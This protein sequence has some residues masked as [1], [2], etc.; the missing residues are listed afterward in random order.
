MAS[1]TSSTAAAAIGDNAH[2]SSIDSTSQSIETFTVSLVR[3][4]GSGSE[5]KGKFVAKNEPIRRSIDADSFAQ[6]KGKFLPEFTSSHLHWTCRR[7]IETYMCSESAAGYMLCS[8]T[9]SSDKDELTLE[10]ASIF[11]PFIEV[12]V[13]H[14]TIRS[15]S[16]GTDDRRW[17]N[18]EEGSMSI[19]K[20]KLD[21][22]TQDLIAKVSCNKMI[23]RISKLDC[24]S[25]RKLVAFMEK[26]RTPDDKQLIRYFKQYWYHD[27]VNDDCGITSRNEIIMLLQPVCPGMVYREVY[28]LSNRDSEDPLAK[29]AFDWFDEE[30]RKVA[31][32]GNPLKLKADE[33]YVT[34]NDE[35]FTMTREK[36][37]TWPDRELRNLVDFIQWRQ[38]VE[39]EEVVVCN[40]YYETVRYSEKRRNLTMVEYVPRRKVDALGCLVAELQIFPPSSY[41]GR[42]MKKISIKD[43]EKAKMMRAGE[44]LR[45]GPLHLLVTSLTG[46]DSDRTVRE[47]K[48]YFGALELCMPGADGQTWSQSHWDK[49]RTKVEDYLTDQRPLIPLP[50]W[51]RTV[52]KAS[53]CYILKN[54]SDRRSIERYYLPTYIIEIGKPINDSD[55]ESA[56]SCANS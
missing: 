25:R 16:L 46:L 51:I 17:Y 35:Q 10:L 43:L 31:I 40:A 50:V 22:R 9:C 24:R 55:S 20:A 3:S 21:S 27:G 56:Q 39:K 19:F 13:S 18:F 8:F 41:C 12:C 26:R 30:D 38:M 28:M 52:L 54:Q 45:S 6:Q 23:H 5:P 36:V 44:K 37:A 15:N 53:H 14:L 32:L 29:Y 4:H 11:G 2:S 7:A 49:L 1:T 48:Y 33:A 47:M 34:A 42:G